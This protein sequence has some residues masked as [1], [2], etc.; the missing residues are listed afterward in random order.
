VPKSDKRSAAVE[1]EGLNGTM[2]TASRG[3]PV[4]PGAPGPSSRVNIA[5]PFSQIAL[6]EPS[7]ELAELAALV[8]DLVA[9][10]AE[11]IPEERLEELEQRAQF[12]REALRH[13]LP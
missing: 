10:M 13:S 8:C 4:S 7:K 12:L 3:D 6:Q 1:N 5:F 2:V 9:A 11:W